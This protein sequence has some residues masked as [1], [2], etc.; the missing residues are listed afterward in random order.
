MSG[1]SIVC[2]VFQGRAGD[3]NDSGIAGAI[4]IGDAL[5]ARTGQPP[6]FIGTP[7]PA[8]NAGWR[9]ELD[10]ALPDLRAMRQH[11]EAVFASGA[12]SVA[13]ISRCAVSLATLP[14]LANQHADACLVWFDAHGDLNTPASSTSSFLGGMALAGPLGLWDSGLGSGIAFTQLVL[15]GQRELDPFESALIEQHNIRYLPPGANLAERLRLAVAG[16]AVYVHLDCD[17]LEP[18]IVPT[19]YQS[20]GG[21]TLAE[22]NACSETLGRQPVLGVEIAEFQQS[23]NSPVSPEP[24]IA[25][26]MPLLQ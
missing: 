22:L 2:T 20:A 12:V 7:K 16:R 4:A 23:D 25:A 5:A 9:E 1:N 10:A 8:L 17:V 18:G 15:V 26:L 6:T 24:L 19:D 21:L 13:A 3:H 14:A 11:M